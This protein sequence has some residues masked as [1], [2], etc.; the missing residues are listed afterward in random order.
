MSK[1]VLVVAIIAATL[2]GSAGVA[3]AAPRVTY[4]VGDETSVWPGE[5]GTLTVFCDP[6]DR[7]KSATVPYGKE[8]AKGKPRI[9]AFFGGQLQGHAK[10]DYVGL[11]RGGDVTMGLTVVC[12]RA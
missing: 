12:V 3:F 2:F 11:K 6:G 9:V 8:V 1:A 10:Q 5:R 4:T 7:V